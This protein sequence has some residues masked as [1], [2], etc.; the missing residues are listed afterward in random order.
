MRGGSHVNLFQHLPPLDAS[1]PFFCGTV[2]HALGWKK[3][4]QFP[5][6]TYIIC[7]FVI[8]II[9]NLRWLLL[10]ITPGSGQED[11]TNWRNIVACFALFSDISFIWI[12]FATN[13]FA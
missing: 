10:S 11:N 7:H 4:G 3:R 12:C 13:I 1:F 5:I 9:A 2:P 8:T 6:N